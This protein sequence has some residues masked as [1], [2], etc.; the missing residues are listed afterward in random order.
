MPIAS[1]IGRDSDDVTFFMVMQKIDNSD[2]V[3]AASTPKNEIQVE[4]EAQEI[5]ALSPEENAPKEREEIV[6]WE[7]DD[8]DGDWGGN[9]APQ[10]NHEASVEQKNVKKN[11]EEEDKKIRAESYKIFGRFGN[12]GL[13]LVIALVFAY[14]IGDFCDRFFGTKPILTVFWL[15]CAVLASFKEVWRSISAARAIADDIHEEK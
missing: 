3:A 9:E 11:D 5:C 13:F 1:G 8:S 6:Q 7:N 14:F 10:A 4:G 12:F 15:V 2:G